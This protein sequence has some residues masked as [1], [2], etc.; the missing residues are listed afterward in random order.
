MKEPHPASNEWERG[1][2]LVKKER[3]YAAVWRAEPK[4]SKK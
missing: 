3:A 1:K 2:V 4:V